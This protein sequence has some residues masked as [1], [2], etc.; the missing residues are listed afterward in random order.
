MTKA[1]VEVEVDLK[2]FSDFD[3]EAEARERGLSASR[4]V[5]ADVINHIKR[6]ET[7]DA[8][9]ALERE[10]FPKWKDSGEASAAYTKAMM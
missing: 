8:I 7:A 1:R 10:F 4:S 2:N 9:T 5:A 3:I 6:G